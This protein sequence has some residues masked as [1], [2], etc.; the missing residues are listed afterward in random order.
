MESHAAFGHAGDMDP[1]GRPARGRRTRSQQPKRSEAPSARA[2]KVLQDALGNEPQ[3]NGS[4]TG[5]NSG[6]VLRALAQLPSGLFVLSSAHDGVRAGALA[7][8]VQRCGVE[9]AM[10]S[11]AI[12]KGHAIEQLIRDSVCFAISA[13]DESH[14]LAIRTF[15]A[16]RTPDGSAEQFDA[17]AWRS[18]T[19]GAPVLRHSLFALDCRMVRHV[20]LEHDFELYIGVVVDGWFAADAA[21]NDGSDL[22]R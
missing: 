18:L 16:D 19:T 2:A 7:H 13:I 10:I 17:I 5:N 21:G 4:R 12:R 6:S 11:V 1:S 9:P 8:W 22:G 20:D 3:R 14:R 15:Q